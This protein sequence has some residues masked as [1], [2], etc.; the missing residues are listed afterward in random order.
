M[1][2][3]SFTTVGDPL[4]I[5]PFD[6]ITSLIFLSLSL[7]LASIRFATLLASTIINN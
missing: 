1:D 4:L 6:S 5:A 2:S 7:S 3:L